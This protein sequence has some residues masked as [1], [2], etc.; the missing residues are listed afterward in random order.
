MTRVADTADPPATSGLSNLVGW[1]SRGLAVL[2]R[3]GSGLS[4]VLPVAGLLI[5]GLVFIDSASFDARSARTLAYGKKQ[6]IWALAGAVAFATACR[7]RPSWLARH[8]WL[9]YGLGLAL[10]AAL[11]VVGTRVNGANRWI[12]LGPVRITPSEFMKLALV[13]GLAGQLRYQG[14]RLRSLGGLVRPFLLTGIPLL[15]VLRQPDLG[16]SLTF[17]PALFAM[18]FVAGVGRR[19]LLISLGGLASA[20]PVAW[21]TVLHRYQRMR[22]L[23][24][25]DPEEHAL[26]VAYQSIQ[27]VI[28]VGNGG[29]DGRGLG[30]GTMGRLGFVPARHTD[31]IF[32]VIAEE[33][34]FW[35]ASGVLVLYLWLLLGLLSV[36]L[37]TREPFGRLAATGVAAILAVQVAVNVGMTLGVAPVTGLPLPFLSYGGS[38]LVLWCGATGCAFGVATRRVATFGRRD[39]PPARLL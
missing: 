24:F 8:A 29:L 10:L 3:P 37:A 14:E 25:L 31:F 22:I 16:T 20:V 5:V 26:G 13:I 21:F 1:L 4:V 34:G 23:A 9:I 15:L 35:V 32:T 28:A 12:V 33:G 36:A 39:G 6:L 17:L 30:L 2:L 11:L 27:S 18:L 38:S 7:V 19:P